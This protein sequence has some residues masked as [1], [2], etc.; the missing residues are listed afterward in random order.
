MLGS[1]L[2]TKQPNLVTWTAPAAKP[3]LLA[4]DLEQRLAL[5][6][7]D[8]RTKDARVEG[9]GVGISLT[10]THRNAVEGL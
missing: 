5:L 4:R 7:Q 3:C 9:G 8:A 1:W 10:L 6:E 2:S